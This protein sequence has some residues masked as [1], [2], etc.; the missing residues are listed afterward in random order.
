MQG[1]YLSTF[2][3]THTLRIKKKRK[4]RPGK[5][6]GRVLLHTVIKQSEPKSES[7]KREVLAES[8][9]EEVLP[10]VQGAALYGNSVSARAQARSFIVARAGSRYRH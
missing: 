3:S 4:K 8:D 9:F 1:A 7:L 10:F 5:G 2:F 6:P